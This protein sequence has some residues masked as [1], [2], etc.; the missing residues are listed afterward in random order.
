V[1]LAPN[2]RLEAAKRQYKKIKEIHFN[3]EVQIE[4]TREQNFVD[5]R[6]RR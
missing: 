3:E 2:I 5:A 1:P 4:E 6:G